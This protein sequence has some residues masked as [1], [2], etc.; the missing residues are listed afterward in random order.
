MRAGNA[1]Q[2]EGAAGPAPEAL[3]DRPIVFLTAVQYEDCLAGRTRRLADGLARLGHDVSFVQ[4]PSLRS[5]AGRVRRMEW[6]VSAPRIQESGVRVCSVPPLPLHSALHDSALGRR[7]A[8]AVVERL[9]CAVPGLDRSA[10][11]CSTPWWL[12]VIE[13]LPYG[14]LVYDCIDHVEVHSGARRSAQYAAWERELMERSAAVLAVGDGLRDEIRSSVPTA[15]ATPMFVVPNGV[16]HDW[17]ESPAPRPPP[18]LAEWTAGARTVGF[19][20]SVFEWVDQALIRSAAELLPDHRFFVIGPTR[21]SVPTDRVRGLPNLRLFPAAAF[22]RV[23]AWIAGADVCLLPFKRNRVT[24][25]A[26]P[27]KVYE[28]CAMGKPVV[29]SIPCRVQGHAAPVRVAG[30][31]TLFAAAIRQSWQQDTPSDGEARRAF[32]RSHTWEARTRSV[33]DILSQALAR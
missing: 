29:S 3:A 17:I 28:Y 6:D 21:P 10:V 31:P 25:L 24:E 9:R 15:R 23:P 8:R 16:C 32:A 14:A 22:E 2:A 18:E 33:R 11:V 13:G 7:W 1:I 20:G 4:L 30:D 5:T 12:H 26:D 27:I 19:V